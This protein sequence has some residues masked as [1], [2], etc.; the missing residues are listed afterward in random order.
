MTTTVTIE[1]IDNGYLITGVEYTP[2]D[3]YGDTY[4]PPKTTRVFA[5]D[6][7]LLGIAVS[8]IFGDGGSAG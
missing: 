6:E 4:T 7:H 1:K 2:T 8:N 5:K 3:E